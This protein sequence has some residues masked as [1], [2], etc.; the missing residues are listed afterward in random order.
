MKK[1][2]QRNV[3]LP[4]PADSEQPYLKVDAV[5][6]CRVNDNFSITC[7]QMNYQSIVSQLGVNGQQIIDKGGYFTVGRFVM[8]YESFCQLRNEV[9]Q[10]HDKYTQQNT[11]ALQN[12]KP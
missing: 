4:D 6:A 5:Q 9:N 11:E 2:T 10:I 8:N 3:K 1:D 12:S 7:H